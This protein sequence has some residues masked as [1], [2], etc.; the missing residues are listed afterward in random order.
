MAVR[1]PASGDADEHHLARK[2]FLGHHPSGQIG[3]TEAK[4]LRRVLHSRVRGWIGR[5]TQL[6]G[7]GVIL[8]QRDVRRG[9]VL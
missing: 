5:F 4:R 8:P 7:A 6:T 3:K 9:A 1:A 2:V